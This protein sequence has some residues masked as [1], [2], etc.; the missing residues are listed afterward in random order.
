[1]QQEW[2]K[3]N[4]DELRSKFLERHEKN[5][6]MEKKSGVK[7]EYVTVRDGRESTMPQGE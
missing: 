1:M 6:E 2:Y 4:R 5:I 7:K 3:Q